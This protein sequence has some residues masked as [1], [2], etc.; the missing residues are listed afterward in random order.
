[1]NEERLQQEIVIWFNN[2]Y[3]LKNNNPRCMVFSI[4]NDSSNFM[5]T[6]RKV[7][8][9]LLRGVSDLILIIP[10][11]IIFVELKRENGKQS[12]AQK[13]FEARVTA[14][15]FEYYLIRSLIKF[16]FLVAQLKI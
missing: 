3:C 11:K 2:N 7:N 6:K 9:G 1:M 10:N 14:L 12:E 16:Q 13:E 15:G 8:T 5:E 4:P